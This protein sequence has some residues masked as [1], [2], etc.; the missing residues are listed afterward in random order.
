VTVKNFFV[1]DLGWK[2]LLGWYFFLTGLPLDWDLVYGLLNLTETA[3]FGAISIGGPLLLPMVEIFRFIFGYLLACLI[4][5]LFNHFIKKFESFK[6]YE[7]P[8]GFDVISIILLIQFLSLF[9][10][11]PFGFLSGLYVSTTSPFLSFIYAWP[12]IIL[13]ILLAI[14]PLYLLLQFLHLRKRTWKIFLIWLILSVVNLII[15]GILS[16]SNVQYLIKLISNLIILGIITW[17]LHGK[18]EVFVN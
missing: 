18:K 13:R 3:E 9:Y 5:P 16:F 6:N 11:L 17:Y 12:L 15:D 4:L 1:N 2:L 8:I 7:R 14:F 10:I